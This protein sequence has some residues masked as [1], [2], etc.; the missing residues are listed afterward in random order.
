MTRT[1]EEV[2]AGGFARVATDELWQCAISPGGV[3]HSRDVAQLARALESQVQILPSRMHCGGKGKHRGKSG[4]DC[5]D[6]QVR[7]WTHL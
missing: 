7:R 4:A 2:A 6:V 5:R 1:A 3:A